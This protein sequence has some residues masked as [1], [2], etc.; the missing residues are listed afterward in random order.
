MS[1]KITKSCWIIGASH[2]IGQSLASKYY[3]S[4]YNIIISAR[5]KDKLEKINDEFFN[6]LEPFFNTNSIFK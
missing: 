3:K 6:N 2:G 4:G 5:S 1:D